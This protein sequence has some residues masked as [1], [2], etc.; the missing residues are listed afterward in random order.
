MVRRRAQYLRQQYRQRYFREWQSTRNLTSTGRPF[1]AMIMPTLPTTACK[2]GEGFPASYALLAPLLDLSSATLPVP[3]KTVRDAPNYTREKSHDPD[4]FAVFGEPQ[5]DRCI[6]K[7]NTAHKEID[8]SD[9][10]QSHQMGWTSPSGYRSLPEDWRT[11]RSWQSPRS[12]KWL[13][14]GFP[15]TRVQNCETTADYDFSRCPDHCSI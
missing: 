12:L 13:C 15:D 2:H 9:M 1:D 4:S 8:V 10:A 3:R 11:K 14:K 7:R 6:G 5:V